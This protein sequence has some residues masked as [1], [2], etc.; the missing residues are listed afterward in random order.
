MGKGKM[1]LRFEEEVKKHKKQ[2]IYLFYLILFL[3]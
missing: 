1:G 2:F 3:L